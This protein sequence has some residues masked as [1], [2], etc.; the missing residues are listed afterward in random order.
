M[1]HRA[2]RVTRGELALVA[3]LAAWG[4]FG[5]PLTSSDGF[6]RQRDP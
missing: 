6:A 3:A 1:T 5:V 4:L 2:R